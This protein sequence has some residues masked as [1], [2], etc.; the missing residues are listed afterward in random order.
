M[1][2]SGATFRCHVTGNKPS[3]PVIV[4]LAALALKCGQ[5]PIYRFTV[6]A[7]GGIARPTYASKSAPVLLFHSIALGDT[8][9]RNSAS[10]FGDI[11]FPPSARAV[12]S[13]AKRRT[14]D[15]LRIVDRPPWCK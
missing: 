14:I 10:S 7:N 8:G 5:P 3:R 4:L 9:P 12:K 6:P 15:E 2:P 13:K 11:G 1:V